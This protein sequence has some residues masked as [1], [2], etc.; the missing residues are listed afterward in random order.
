M[1]VE[2]L[3]DKTQSI[4]DSR[5]LFFQ[6]ESSYFEAFKAI[7]YSIPKK[8]D[9]RIITYSIVLKKLLFNTFSKYS[10]VIELPKNDDITYKSRL[11][12]KW[13]ISNFDIEITDKEI[14][15]QK[16]LD[17]DYSVSEAAPLSIV[18]SKSIIS[19]YFIPQ[20]LS[21]KYFSRLLN[22]LLNYKTN[23]PSYP[24][25][26]K[27]VFNFIGSGIVKSNPDNDFIANHIKEDT[28]D[29]YEKTC[30]F[31]ILSTYP[32]HLNSHLLSDEWLN[33]LSNFKPNL[34]ELDLSYFLKSK[35]NCFKNLSNELSIYFSSIKGKFNAVSLSDFIQITSGLLIEELDFIISELKSHPDFIS[36][37]TIN[38]LK[39]HFQFLDYSEL[40]ELDELAMSIKPDYKLPDFDPCANLDVV[41]D[42]AVK[43][44]LPY[45]FWSDATKIINSDIVD[46]GRNF[47]GY[48]LN[49]Y[50]QVS[51]N[52]D[53]FT[54]RFI[55]NYI[56]KIK[57]TKL[58]II[59]VLDNFNF[60]FF[61]I[62]QD[63][64]KSQNIILANEPDQYL[65][66]LPTITSVG[67]I[68]IY[69][70]KRDKLDSSTLNYENVIK[71]SWHSYFPE[72]N[73]KYFH[74]K[75][76]ELIDYTVSGK[77]II[78][79]NY[80]EVDEEL[81][82][83]SNKTLIE[84]KKIIDFKLKELTNHIVK[85]IKKNRCEED[86]KLFFI[87]DHG[88][89]LLNKEYPNEIDLPYFK[90]FLKNT[91][92]KPG[93]R[94]I[95]VDE[96]R[97]DSL[98]SNKNIADSIF[99]L[100]SANSGDGNNYIIARSYNRF[101][102][103]DDFS[104]VHG[105]ALPEE[106]IVPGGYFSYSTVEHSTLIVQLAKNEFRYLVLD[107][108]ELRIANPNDKLVEI[109][110]LEIFENNIPKMKIYDNYAIEEKSEIIIKNSIKISSKNLDNLTF[111]IT[112]KIGGT[113]FTQ[114]FD[115]PVKI[116]SMVSGGLDLENL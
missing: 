101:E 72:H 39:S 115:L 26:V 43:Y 106:I 33:N 44:Y 90:D 47:S 99:P 35:N 77:E 110:C 23:E 100:N 38:K 112:Y 71:E 36:K 62:L 92:H 42:Q 58:S 14:I 93:H 53:F 22:D 98:K 12:E 13:N 51:Y 52:Y 104:Y 29:L 31:K 27:S 7:Y 94:Y 96:N 20:A 97:F 55:H 54:Y 85:F 6:D 5:A 116:K 76:G 84:H 49:K 34:S 83:S 74:S 56:E 105:G 108:F 88:S 2:I 70:G 111:T 64:F 69:A 19:E 79:I 113:P 57:E 73:L 25:I 45:K 11:S 63:H 89:S 102:T 48:I 17:Y 4:K 3:L 37:S 41:L 107:N 46:W 78:F 82:N 30:V 114:T 18:V 61:N 16:L 32:V 75:L 91:D 10:N 81:H 24:Q 68:S 109:S 50:E 87:S 8:E 80:L 66:N 28:I 65:C 1:K 60:K 9:I 86:F 95:R 40:S 67:K 15:N 103:T 59:L 21:P